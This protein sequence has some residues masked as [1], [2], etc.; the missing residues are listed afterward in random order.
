MARL[1]L[2][3]PCQLADRVKHVF[4]LPLKLVLHATAK[5]VGP[6]ERGWWTEGRR[7]CR[8]EKPAVDRIRVL[9]Q[10]PRTYLKLGDVALALL[11]LGPELVQL[12]RLRVDLLLQL[13]DPTSRDRLV[14]AQLA[15][16]NMQHAGHR[17][18]SIRRP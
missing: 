7:R 16:R 6:C 1:E 8:R 3:L 5:R 17:T 2:E 14:A 10:Y 18:S 9:M 15:A 13:S 12:A 11:V 4:A